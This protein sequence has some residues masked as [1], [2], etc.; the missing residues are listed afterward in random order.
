MLGIPKFLDVVN[1][2]AKIFTEGDGKFTE[3]FLSSVHSEKDI[4]F[5]VTFGPSC[6]HLTTY[7]FSLPHMCLSKSGQMCTGPKRAVTRPF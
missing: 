2:N 6:S 1:V 5:F 3:Y 4:I 7:K